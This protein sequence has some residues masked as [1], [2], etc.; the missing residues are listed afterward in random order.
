MATSIGRHCPTSIP[1]GIKEANPNRISVATAPEYASSSERVNGAVGSIDN[2]GATIANTVQT[3]K[4]TIKPRTTGIDGSSRAFKNT[5][6]ST[7]MT[8]AHKN[9][10]Q[11]ARLI[12]TA[13]RR[14]G[15]STGSTN[16]TSGFT[17]SAVRSI[18]NN[19][20]LATARPQRAPSERSV[21]TATSYDYRTTRCYSTGLAAPACRRWYRGS[22][23]ANSSSTHS[24]SL[25]G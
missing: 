10:H 3:E 9:T 12:R 19:R 20:S 25:R 11:R 6:A 16:K 18:R 21:I 4:A 7:P 22:L 8:L 17:P 2:R 15:R 13:R 1:A 5:P 24:G 23:G 14:R